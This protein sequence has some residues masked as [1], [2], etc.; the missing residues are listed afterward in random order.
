MKKKDAERRGR[1]G[2][3]V[4][5]MQLAAL[6]IFALCAAVVLFFWGWWVVHTVMAWIR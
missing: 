5:K 2:S 6:V 4:Q 3:L 1:A